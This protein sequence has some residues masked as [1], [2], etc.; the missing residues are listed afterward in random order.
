VSRFSGE[1][2]IPPNVVRSQT[3]QASV[4]SAATS[5]TGWGRP[6]AEPHCSSGRPD[7]NR[8]DSVH[9]KGML[10]VKVSVM[11]EHGTTGKSFVAMSREFNGS[12]NLAMLPSTIC[13]RSWLLAPNPAPGTI[14]PACPA[15][16]ARRRSCQKRQVTV[17]AAS[18]PGS[19]SVS[20]RGPDPLR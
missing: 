18:S 15:D 3:S 7:L 5:L 19:C 8:P 11:M 6:P 14:P 13:S 17:P 9:A 16:S 10:A 20:A 12:S 1:A 2:F 4:S